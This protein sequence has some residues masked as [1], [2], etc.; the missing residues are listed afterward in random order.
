M[1]SSLNEKSRLFSALLTYFLVAY[2]QYSNLFTAVFHKYLFLLN[3]PQIFEF[4]DELALLFIRGF[5]ISFATGIFFHDPFADLFSTRRTQT[6][7]KLSIPIYNSIT[8]RRRSRVH[9]ARKYTAWQFPINI[10]HRN[11][12]MSNRRSVKVGHLSRRHQDLREEE[13]PPCADIWSRYLP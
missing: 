7:F 10:A 4:F 6:G 3:F 8:L 11:F 1:V 13:G 9:Q 12:T 5:L 2:N